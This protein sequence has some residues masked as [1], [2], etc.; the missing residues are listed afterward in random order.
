MNR[1]SVVLPAYN[2]APRLAK[3]IE[4]VDAYM[5]K[6]GYPYEIIIA[7]DGS[8]DGTDKIA[9]EISQK[10]EKVKH[11]HFNEK[12]GRGKALTNAFLKSEGEILVYLD[13]DLSTDMKHLKELI[14]SIALE[15]YDFSTGSR[16]M[17]ESVRERSFKRDF[18]SK[19]F[20]FLVKFLLNSTIHDHQC[21]FKAFRKGAFLELKDKIK[22]THW[23]WDTEVLITAQRESYKVKEFPVEW[24]QGSNTTVRFSQDV[25]YMLSQILR[26]WGDQLKTSRKFFAFSIILAGVILLSLIFYAGVE[27]VISKLRTADPYLIGLAALIYSTSY[28][29][30]GERYR[31]IMSKLGHRIPIMFSTESISVSQ[32]VNVI[33]PVRVGD[34]ARAYIFK[35]KE[36]P[37]T[38]SFSGLAI[39][40]VFDI[41]AVVVLSFA[42]IISLST[43]QY[44]SLPIYALLL[45]ITAIIMAVFLSRMENI[46][47]KIMRDFKNV[48]KTT[49]SISILSSS[50]VVWAIDILTAH[51]IMLAFGFDVLPLVVLAVSIANISKILPLTPGGIGTYE[52]VM[53]GILAISVDKSV[54]LPVSLIDHALKNVVTLILGILA[55][56]SLNVKL[57]DVR[58]GR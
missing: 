42:A 55:L 7:E 8:T 23:F 35:L 1:V 57:N 58:K 21:G 13:V 39:E 40:R 44:A 36:V 15:G 38:T 5:E 9:A 46:L 6:T 24:I 34:F 45:S 11:L 3:A 43:I 29:V 54:A 27:D 37:F 12:Q 10:N 4:T 32:T 22:D 48:I 17:K 30:R 25:L 41:I 56:T 14:D 18:A 33:T 20:N 49:A 2:E 31:Y 51:V 52:I 26:M 47:G 53:T 28:L 16:L 19:G 50:L